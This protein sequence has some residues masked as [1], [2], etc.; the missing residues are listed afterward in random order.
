MEEVV[1][2]S[3]VPSL[4]TL[5]RKQQDHSTQEW[6]SITF[7]SRWV[8]AGMACVRAV[9]CTLVCCLHRGQ[10]RGHSSEPHALL[11][12]NYAARRKDVLHTVVPCSTSL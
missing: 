10:H 11:A 5:A 6:D 8:R 3:I 2:A 12:L 9:H 4:R 1:A 7:H